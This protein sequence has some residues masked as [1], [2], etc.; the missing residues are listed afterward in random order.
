MSNK[1]RE[2]RIIEDVDIAALVLTHQGIPP[3]PITRDDRK[4]VFEFEEDVMPSLAIYWKNE[5]V[6]IADYLQSLRRVKSILA[7]AKRNKSLPRTGGN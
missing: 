4:I 7:S 5:P 6:P 1:E 2:E 3:K